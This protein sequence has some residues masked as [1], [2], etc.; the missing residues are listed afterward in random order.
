MDYL[1]CLEITC[2]LRLYGKAFRHS[3]FELAGEAVPVNHALNRVAVAGQALLTPLA[4]Q[5]QHIPI[6]R[7]QP[8]KHRHGEQRAWVAPSRP[9]YRWLRA[10]ELHPPPGRRVHWKA[11]AS[12]RR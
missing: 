5:L 2:N 7:R 12:A 10:A 1:P 4:G 11:L 6:I 8:G 9:G 3:R